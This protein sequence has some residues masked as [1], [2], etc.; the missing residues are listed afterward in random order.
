[1]TGNYS[2]FFFNVGIHYSLVLNFTTYRRL[3]QSLITL[4]KLDSL[5]SKALQ[6]WRSSTA[7][8]REHLKKLYAGDNLT[9][10]RFHTSPVVFLFFIHQMLL[11]VGWALKFPLN[12]GHFLPS[13]YWK[14]KRFK[15]IAQNI[16]IT[17]ILAYVWG[18][19]NWTSVQLKVHRFVT[20]SSGF[21][22]TVLLFIYLFCRE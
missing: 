17:F 3:I 22:I 10:W 19:A 20:P 1:M 14:G 2:V 6:I 9:K 4:L 13:L 16:R 11:K 15:K 12:I 18:Y 21:R 5:G 7:I 8:E